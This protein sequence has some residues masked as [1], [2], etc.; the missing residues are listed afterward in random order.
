V[1]V[2]V[3]TVADCRG[4]EVRE[5]STV[6]TAGGS[7]RLIE[8]TVKRIESRRTDGMPQAVPFV[9]M[10]DGSYTTPDRLAVVA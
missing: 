6:V 3:E 2:A 5:G 4:V 1:S 9:W 7:N 10:T 8:R